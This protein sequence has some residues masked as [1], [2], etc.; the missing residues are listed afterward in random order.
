MTPSHSKTRK[1]VRL[2]YYISH[3]LI[4]QSGVTNQGGWRLPAVELEG[5]IAQLVSATLSQHGL[6]GTLVPGATADQIANIASRLAALSV[7]ASVEDKL[8]LI[9]RVDIDAGSLTLQLDKNTLTNALELD[10]TQIDTTTLVSTHPFQRRKRG[11]ETKIVLAD[12]PAAQDEILLRN[13]ARAHVWFEQIRTGKSFADIAAAESTSTRRIQQLIEL[14]FLSPNIVR[15]VVDGT[16][17]LGFTSEFCQRKGLPSAWQ[18]QR[19]LLAT[20]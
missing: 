12:S 10:P 2:R 4:A 6:A 9:A 18:D 16:Q 17:P 13:I 19:Q 5:K 14:A 7:S 15:E 8:A 1:G 11:V 20:L 3:R